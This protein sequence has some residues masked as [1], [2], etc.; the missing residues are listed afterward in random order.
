MHDE[1][2]H[3]AGVW[4]ESRDVKTV[5]FIDCGDRAEMKLDL[6][7]AKFDVVECDRFGLD[8]ESVGVPVEANVSEFRI[9]L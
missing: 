1:F 8:T 9:D 3:S 4:I 7:A 2:I 6:K 5:R